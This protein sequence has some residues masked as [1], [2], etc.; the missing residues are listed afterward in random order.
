MAV[1]GV[2]YNYGWEL[3][4]IYTS[5]DES[6]IKDLLDDAL[7]FNPWISKKKEPEEIPEDTREKLRKERED[8]LNGRRVNARPNNHR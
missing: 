5:F 4:Y 2:A 8:W 6:K 1:H 3:E 7:L